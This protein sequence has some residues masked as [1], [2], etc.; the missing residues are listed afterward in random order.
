M[1]DL[2][3]YVIRHYANLMTK[4]EYLAYKA[5][6]IDQKAESSPP[7]LAARIR[8]TWGTED[9]TVRAMLDQGSEKLMQAI[10]D[11]IMRDHPGELIINRCI[12]CGGLAQTPKAKQC[13]H[14]GYDW[15]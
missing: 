8:K 4:K 14:C 6:I 5:L 10:C 15:H 3:R 2:A 11:R 12:K 13:L 7:A 1:D 9:P